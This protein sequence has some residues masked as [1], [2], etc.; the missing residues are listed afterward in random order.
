MKKTIFIL[1]NHEKKG[2]ISVPVTQ[3]NENTQ[4]MIFLLDKRSSNAFLSAA[5][6]SLA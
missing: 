1:S 3:Q 2:L 6:G 4:H 5:D